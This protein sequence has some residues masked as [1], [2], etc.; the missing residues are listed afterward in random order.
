MATRRR[1]GGDAE[2]LGVAFLEK[3]GYRVIERNYRGPQGEVDVIAEAEDK[4]LCFVEIRSRG[5]GSAGNWAPAS[6]VRQEKQRRIARTA[7]DWL[8]RNKITRRACR[9][10]V[11]S[12]TYE[13]GE[14]VFELYQN[15][16]ETGDV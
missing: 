5:P 6:T 1:R 12:V 4:T 8:V 16:F 2:R 15:A 7:R 3:R 11:L 10:D 14:P 13:E 9:F